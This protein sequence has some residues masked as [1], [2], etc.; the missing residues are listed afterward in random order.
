MNKKLPK[1]RTNMERHSQRK[2]YSKWAMPNQQRMSLTRARI[3]SRKIKQP[4]LGVWR[5]IGKDQH[6]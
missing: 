2:S 5:G 1:G 4:V 3:I 6:G